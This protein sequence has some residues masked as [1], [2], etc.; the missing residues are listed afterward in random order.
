MNKRAWIFGAVAGVVLAVCG[1]TILDWQ[2]WFGCF[3][4]NLAY[5]YCGEPPK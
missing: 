1:Q 5:A 2:F 3:A 4:L